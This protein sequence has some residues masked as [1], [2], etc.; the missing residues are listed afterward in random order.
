MKLPLVATAP[1]EQI[2]AGAAPAEE[3]AI[4]VEGLGKTYGARRAVRALDLSV[5]HGCRLAVIGPNGAGKSTLVRLLALLTRPTSGRITIVGLDAAREARELRRSFGAVLHD[6]LLYPD[7]TVL[8]NLHFAARLYAVSN[9]RARLAHLIDEFALG[10]L[11][12]S[13]VRQ[14]SRGQRQ[15]VCLARALVHDPPLLL[16]D[17]PDTGL[18][19]RSWQRVAQQLCSDPARTV[20][21]TSHDVVHALDLATELLLLRDGRATPLGPAQD[22]T[23]AGLA[24]VLLA[25]GTAKP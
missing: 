19:A 23:A 24:G 3:Q 18:D 5:A 4:V 8:E 13:R 2:E 14:L 16:L 9:E 6:S 25:A 10:R 11:A 7:L 21:F 20:V 17:E 1:E 22:W 15:R 12:G